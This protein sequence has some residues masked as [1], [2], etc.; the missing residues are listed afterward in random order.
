MSDTTTRP[1][2]T[3]SEDLRAFILILEDHTRDE[4]ERHE[5]LLSAVNDARREVRDLRSHIDD[6]LRIST[7]RDN[8]QDSY[9]RELV[10]GAHDESAGARRMAMGADWKSI[11]AIVVAVCGAIVTMIS[12]GCVP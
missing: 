8:V 7:Q 10:K 3:V 4:T 2:V 5:M 6:Q 9:I 1:D 12:G 11:A